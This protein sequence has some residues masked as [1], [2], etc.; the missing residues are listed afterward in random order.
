[1]EAA[2]IAKEAEE[3][4]VRRQLEANKLNAATISLVSDHGGELVDQP[5]DGLCGLHSVSHQ[6]GIHNVK[7]TV[8][9]LQGMIASKYEGNPERSKEFPMRIAFRSC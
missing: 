9:M 1:M 2:R 8:P 6:L 3:A 4:R 5:Y 7:A